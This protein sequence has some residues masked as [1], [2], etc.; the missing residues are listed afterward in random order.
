MGQGCLFLMKIM[1]QGIKLVTK[2]WDRVSC[3]NEN[4]EKVFHKVHKLSKVHE[5][6]NI[7][8]EDGQTKR[9]AMSG[10]PTCMETGSPKGDNQRSFG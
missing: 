7:G 8:M 6:K 2:L 10:K 3:G 5:K 1:R 4:Y 9:N